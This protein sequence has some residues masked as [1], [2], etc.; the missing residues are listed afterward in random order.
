[1]QE[2]KFNPGD[3]VELKSGSPKMTVL[4]SEEDF[5]YC[6]Y[7]IPQENRFEEEKKIPTV[8]LRVSDPGNVQ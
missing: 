4:R 3:I 2:T 5:T 6:F 7:Y 8:L 1:M